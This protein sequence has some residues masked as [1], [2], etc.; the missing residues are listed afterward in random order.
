[1]A[2][3]NTFIVQAGL[4]GI[5]NNTQYVEF[6]LPSPANM[7]RYYFVNIDVQDQKILNNIESIYQENANNQNTLPEVTSSLIVKVPLQNL[8]KT[9]L[10]NTCGTGAVNDIGNTSQTMSQDLQKCMTEFLSLPDNATSILS[11]SYNV[12]SISNI[13]LNN[14][15]TIV[16]SIMVNDTKKQT[17]NFQ[18]SSP[19]IKLA[20]GL[21]PFG[22]SKN[23]SI[24]V[25]AD[26]LTQ[27]II[28]NG[29][30]DLEPKFVIN[31]STGGIMTQN[32]MLYAY[33]PTP[34]KQPSNKT[35]QTINQPL[36]LSFGP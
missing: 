26:G 36:S 34:F 17:N 9:C 12:K 4:G 2:S 20:V 21:P 27:G 14:S 19:G 6:A 7:A 33:Q 18:I 11:K 24:V 35:R 10:N 29:S 30:G 8:I 1:V 13:K 32:N 5:S 23:N 16:K 22:Y 15:S 3:A 28:I 25:S 31:G